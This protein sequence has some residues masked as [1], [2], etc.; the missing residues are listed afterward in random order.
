MVS[1][2]GDAFIQRYIRDIGAGI[3]KPKLTVLARTNA[4]LFE[5]V[6]LCIQKGVPCF[7]EGENVGKMVQVSGITVGVGP[8]TASSYRICPGGA[9]R[10]SVCEIHRR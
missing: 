10:L 6:G 2:G 1:L 9:Q 3:R 7:I 5:L 4:R 8:I